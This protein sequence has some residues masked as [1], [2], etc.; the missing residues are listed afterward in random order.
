MSNRKKLRV[1]L[2][3][4]WLG[5]LWG[6]VLAIVNSV[7]VVLASLS[8]ANILN[9]IIEADLDMF[10]RYCL[11]SLGLFLLS[12][13]AD[14]LYDRNSARIKANVAYDIRIS[15]IDAIQSSSYQAFSQRKSEDY[16]AMMVTD[17]DIIST[18]I[19]N[20]YFRLISNICNL[21]ASILGLIY[22]HYSLLIATFVLAIIMFTLPGLFQGRMQV[23]AQN[24]ADRNNHLL[25]VATHW[26]GGFRTLNDYDSR[27][28][29]GHHI[30]QP[31]SDVKDAVI[32]DEYMQATVSMI[33]GILSM[34]A[35]VLLIILT[36]Y[37]S[38]QN[39]VTPGA[40]LSTGNLAGMIFGPLSIII[41]YYVQFQAGFGTLDK[42]EQVYRSLIPTDEP[43][44]AI[45]SGDAFQLQSSD[46]SVEFEDGR[47][48]SIP[49]VQFNTR[50]NYA[51]VGESGVGKSVF[52]NLIAKNLNNYQGSLRLNGEEL[53]NLLERDVKDHI[54]YV[55]QST[56]LFN[57]TAKENIL[58]GNPDATEEEYQRAVENAGLESTF[59]SWQDGDQT[60][61]GD[62]DTSVSGGQAQRIGIARALIDNKPIM[63]FDEVTA[64]LNS[65]VAIDIDRVIA[66]I[67]N[68]MKL[69]V[70]HHV[71]EMNRPLYDEIISFDR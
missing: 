39:I 44:A 63:L 5:I 71:N 29:I 7:G 1:W 24:V 66:Q 50:N 8:V 20:N 40:V 56:Y 47:R 21:L 19:L 35:Q 22:L 64:N 60:I 11:I 27:D 43:S 4:Y 45:N 54:S 70:T 37:L 46:L 31:T 69:S 58:L 6:I 57:M 10:Y 2:K 48:V 67:P 41:N 38:L 36:G 49:D 68:R 23:L 53:A 3:P 15:G 34:L 30:T 65:E 25:Q 62:S 12:I 14:Y 61:I 32:Q 26:L 13:L 55:P 33:S 51:I 28:L 16:A 18:R 52:L 59:A 17:L 9:A 42:V